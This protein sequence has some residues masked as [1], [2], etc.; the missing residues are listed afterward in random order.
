MD[1][2]TIKKIRIK[3]LMTRDEFAKSVGVSAAAITNWESGTHEISMRNWRK[4][5][6]FCQEKG[7]D[8]EKL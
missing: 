6:A 1:K 8:V 4:V 2:E 3:A 5:L 7:I